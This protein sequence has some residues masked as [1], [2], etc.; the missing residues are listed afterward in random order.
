MP[1][2]MTVMGMSAVWRQKQEKMRCSPL[3]T[4][5][6]KRKSHGE[7]RHTG[8]NALDISYSYNVWGQLLE[9]RRSGVSVCYAYDKAGNRIKKTDKQGAT[10]Y[11]FNGK[12]QLATEESLAG[13]C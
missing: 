7:G 13:I 2:T 4:G 9:E 10:I 5:M 3:H 12:N 1:M 6:R 11:Q 8:S